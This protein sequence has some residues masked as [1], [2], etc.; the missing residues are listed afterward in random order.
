MHI[1]IY[2]I[3]A[4]SYYIYMYLCIYKDVS[5]NLLLKPHMP[6]FSELPNFRFQYQLIPMY[7]AV[8]GEE[9]PMTILTHIT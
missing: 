5:N 1:H 9:K 7:A 6:I 4:Y 3:Y 2:S 8:L